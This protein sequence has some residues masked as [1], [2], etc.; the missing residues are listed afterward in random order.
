MPGV[1]TVR[2][3]DRHGNLLSPSQA[4]SVMTNGSHGWANDALVDPT[5]LQDLVGAPL[6]ASGGSLVF[7]VPA[8]P[9]ALALNWPTTRGYS[10]VIVDD[11]GGGFTSAGTVN[12]T[13]Q[14]ALD[15]KRRLDAMVAARPD[16]APS[17]AFGEADGRAAS[18]IQRAT[19]ATDESDRGASV[20][21]R[22]IR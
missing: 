10:L 2:F 13:Y 16:Y 11:G 4:R 7:D 14:A 5:T 19:Q 15:A 12:F 3:Y 21:A 6:H 22:S 8:Q 20:N 18:L 9:V 1:V 17:A